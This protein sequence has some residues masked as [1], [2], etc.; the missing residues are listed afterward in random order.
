MLS[1]IFKKESWEAW[2]SRP[3]FK[4]NLPLNHK[5]TDNL[6]FF[7]LHQ[8]LLKPTYVEKKIELPNKKKPKPKAQPK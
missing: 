4:C 8:T 1:G 6:I 3:W 7:E 5:K 2:L